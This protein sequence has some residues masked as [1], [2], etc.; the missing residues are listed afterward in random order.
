M[1]PRERGTEVEAPGRPVE[2]FGVPVTNGTPNV[3]VWR[4]CLVRVARLQFEL[5][6]VT[7]EREE[8]AN[9]KGRGQQKEISGPYF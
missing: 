7:A 3:D 9:W 1:A 8:Q 2:K 4:R 6:Q 5:A